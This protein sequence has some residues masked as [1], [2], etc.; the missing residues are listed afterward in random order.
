MVDCRYMFHGKAAHAPQPAT[1]STLLAA[2]IAKLANR[3][4]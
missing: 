4:F 1:P 3:R 2:A